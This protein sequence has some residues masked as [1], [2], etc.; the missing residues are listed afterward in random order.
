MPTP[1]K[2]RP[3]PI[4]AFSRA[5]SPLGE[6]FVNLYGT[7]NKHSDSVLYRSVLSPLISRP[8]RPR[9]FLY[10]TR[11]FD[12]PQ[13]DAAEISAP[14]GPSGGKAGV[15]SGGRRRFGDNPRPPHRPAE[16][17]ISWQEETGSS[18]RRNSEAATREQGILST[19]Q[20]WPRSHFARPTGDLPVD[21]SAPPLGRKGA[22]RARDQPRLHQPAGVGDRAAR[23]RFASERLTDRRKQR[24]R[25]RAASDCRRTARR[26]LSGNAR[27][28]RSDDRHR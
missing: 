28:F 3:L 24:G 2:S 11:I 16:H 22:D 18:T 27:I 19:K 9:S 8:L 10:C 20:G 5:C 17:C 14:R 25:P 4:R 12:N 21:V 23:R 13:E 7:N 15:P 26:R 1:D 6:T